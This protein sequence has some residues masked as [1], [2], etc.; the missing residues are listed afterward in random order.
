[1]ISAI[2]H[3]CAE[4]LGDGSVRGLT[5]NRKWNFK[6]HLRNQH[7]QSQVRPASIFVVSHPKVLLSDTA[8]V[9]NTGD[10]LTDVNSVSNVNPT[11]K[12]IVTGTPYSIRAIAGSVLSIDSLDTIMLRC[13]YSAKRLYAFAVVILRPA[14]SRGWE[15]PALT[16]QIR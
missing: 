9:S 3:R 1:M 2:Q 11:N 16:G 8:T 4:L 5:F 7:R 12:H 13:A 15:S 10:V 14:S 6:R